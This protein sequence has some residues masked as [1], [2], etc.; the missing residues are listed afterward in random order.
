MN[1]PVKVEGALRRICWGVAAAVPLA[2]ISVGIG[3]AV[4]GA[5]MLRGCGLLFQA[6]AKAWRTYD[7]RK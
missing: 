3:L 5:L 4:T 7:S 6:G 2:I 1:Q